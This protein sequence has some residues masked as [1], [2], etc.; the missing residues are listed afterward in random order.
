MAALEDRDAVESRLA[1]ALGRAGSRAAGLVNGAVNDGDGALPEA[2]WADIEALYRDALIG[3][4]EAIF[5]T[6]ASA[7]MAALGIGVDFDVIN[8]AA[9]DFAQS[10]TFT[11]VRGITNNSRTVLQSAV[12]DYFNQRLTQRDLQARVS[13]TFGPAR[14]ATIS[15]TEVT[16]AAVAGEL[17][18]A[19]SLGAQG[20]TVTHVWQTSSDDRTCPICSPRQGRAQGDG[21]QDYPPA[22]VNCRCWLSTEVARV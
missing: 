18:V 20:V 22:H 6:S 10:Y 7:G 17:A 21:W 12:S 4:L 9:A 2:L 14:A 16:R 3:E 5:V 8:R 11:L 13:R 1:R 19:Q 15:V